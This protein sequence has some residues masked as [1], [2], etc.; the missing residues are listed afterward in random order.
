VLLLFAERF[1]YWNLG[2]NGTFKSGGTDLCV[3]TGPR[4]MEEDGLTSMLS[5]CLLLCCRLEKFS[6]AILLGDP[7]DSARRRLFSAS[8]GDKV[9]NEA[10]P[11][12]ELTVHS[13]GS[14]SSTEKK[15]FLNAIDI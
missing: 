13:F 3:V 11:P 6:G 15:I 8:I 2:D 12:D 10:R 1:R 5:S 14:M 7:I 9:L 4:M